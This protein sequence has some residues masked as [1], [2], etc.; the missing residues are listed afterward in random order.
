MGILANAEGGHLGG[1]ILIA[2]FA[3]L[4]LFDMPYY[5]PLKRLNKEER[6]RTVNNL[7]RLRN[8]LDSEV[9]QKTANDTLL[10]AT[11]NIRKF[12]DNRLLESL[13]YI[14]EI[15]SRF[16]L[17]AVQEV[18][19]NL[20]GLEKLLFLLGND[21]DY[22]VT[23]ST[24]GSAGGGE[25]LAFVY[26][27]SKVCFKK[28]AGEIVLPL[29][30]L[31]DGKLQ[32]ARTPYTVSF[33]AGWFKFILT[34]VHIFYGSTAAID[35]KKREKEIDM[36]T[37]ILSKRAK[38]ENVSYILIGDFNIPDVQDNT[39]KAL[40]KYGFSVPEAIKEHPSDL[41]ATKHYDQIAFNLKLDDRMTLFSETEQKAGAFNFAKTVYTTEELDSYRKYFLDKV[42]GKSEKDIE[43][44]YLSSWR[45]FEMSDH[46][47]LWVELKS[48][49]L[50]KI[51]SRLLKNCV[52]R[53]IKIFCSSAVER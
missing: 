25:R 28:M 16:D 43:K 1:W 23:D 51:S 35:K 24:D 9:P 36:L 48:V 45:T 2:N 4:I 44:Y 20:K 53:R 12:G 41:G 29:D 8:Q 22:I 49:T 40:E 17:V 47:P 30:K 33:Q 3:V 14:A 32:F 5:Y 26:D 39:M 46:L 18:S 42:T 27:K 7:L 15:V 38:K 50:R 34:P 37:S 11:W 21:W 13:F 52:N 31:I 10:L 6:M 19:A